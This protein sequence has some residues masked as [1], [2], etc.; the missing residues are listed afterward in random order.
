MRHSRYVIGEDGDFQRFVLVKDVGDGM[1][2]AI[3]FGDWRFRTYFKGITWERLSRLIDGY[4]VVEEVEGDL[5][6]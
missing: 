6:R 3:S 4:S 1:Y 5:P 2:D